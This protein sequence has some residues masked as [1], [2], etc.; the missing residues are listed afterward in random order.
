VLKNKTGVSTACE[1]LKYT[2]QKLAKS[3]IICYQDG[4]YIQRGGM[5]SVFVEDCHLARIFQQT[6][7]RNL[8][9]ITEVNVLHRIDI[10]ILIPIGSTDETP[11]Y[12]SMQL[13][14]TVS[15]KTN[16]VVNETLGYVKLQ[17]EA[18]S[19]V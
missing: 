18:A 15:V 9:L 17:I 7:R 14:Y 1:A 16:C 13:N 12:C 19:V 8:L 11:M 3:H 2:G 4:M 5:V 6:L 10:Y